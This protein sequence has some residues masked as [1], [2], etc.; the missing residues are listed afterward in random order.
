MRSTPSVFFCG[1]RQTVGLVTGAV[2][3]VV[4]PDGKQ[5]KSMDDFE[6]G[7]PYICCGAEPLKKDQSEL[8]YNIVIVYCLCLPLHGDGR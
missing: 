8:L 6:D 4:T 7:K 5:I 2:F 1:F 3:K